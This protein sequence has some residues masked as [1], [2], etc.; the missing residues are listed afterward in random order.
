MSFKF[1]LVLIWSFF[2]SICFSGCS[3]SHKLSEL[4]KTLKNLKKEKQNLILAEKNNSQK[5]KL[6]NIKLKQLRE[7]EKKLNQKLLTLVEKNKDVLKCETGGKILKSWK[8]YLKTHDFFLIKES[9]KRSIKCFFIK[10]FKRNYKKIK[11][12]IDDLK[13]DLKQIEENILKTEK[14][15]KDL[16][17]KNINIKEKL[18]NL[19][20]KI[21]EIQEEIK[22][23]KSFL[24]RITLKFLKKLKIQKS[25]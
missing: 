9:A 19:E 13:K 21:E 14:R 1:F 5:I 20:E 2:L 16:I 8:D 18:I 6:L 25:Y 22:C 12:E 3:Q 24:C 7:E 4:K 15:E 11:K 10:I 23:E 17:K